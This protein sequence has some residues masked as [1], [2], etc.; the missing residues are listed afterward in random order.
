MHF[1]L[2]ALHSLL[3]RSGCRNVYGADYGDGYANGGGGYYDPYGNPQGMV[4]LNPAGA[5]GPDYDDDAS[6]FSTP[7]SRRVMREIIV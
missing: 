5:V 3:I 1:F 7:N 4:D 2:S 6:S